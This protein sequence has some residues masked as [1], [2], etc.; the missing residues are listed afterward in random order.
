[1][2]L[3]LRV[4]SYLALLVIVLASCS[5][6]SVVPVPADASFVLHIDGGAFHSKFGWDEFKKGSLY[7][8]AMT[9]KLDSLQKEILENPEVSGIDIKS[10]L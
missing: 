2:R 7:K 9:K 5:D 6:K 10:E 3:H 1:M 4:Y 8:L